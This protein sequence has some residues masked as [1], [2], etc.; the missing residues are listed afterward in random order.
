MLLYIKDYRFVHAPENPA[1]SVIQA[2]FSSLIGKTVSV[3]VDSGGCVTGILMEVLPDSIPDD[4]APVMELAI[5]A[6]RAVTRDVVTPGSRVLIIGLGPSGLIMA[7]RA[8][9]FGAE[10]VVGWDLFEMRRQAGLKAGCDAVFSPDSPDLLKL[11][12]TDGGFDVIVDAMGND[13]LGDT[14]IKGIELSSYNA[15]IVS[16]GHPTVPRRFDPFKL[17]VKKNTIVTP[18]QDMNLIQK[19]A[20]ETTEMIMNKQ[21]SL[22]LLITHH[23]KLPEIGRAL[24]LVTKKQ[25]E[26]LKIILDIE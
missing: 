22:K 3:Y 7:Q 17:Q 18:V 13:V 1:P 23:M 26:C 12:K 4:E 11:S 9:A 19:L 15:K 24:D 14:L 20:D 16:Y 6:S 21:I 8:R 10:T 2:E 25:N 5:A